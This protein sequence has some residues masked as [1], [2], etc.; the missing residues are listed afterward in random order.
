[1]IEIDKIDIG[2]RV[3]LQPFPGPKQEKK[4]ACFGRNPKHDSI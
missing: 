4:L 2:D 1:M 3:L